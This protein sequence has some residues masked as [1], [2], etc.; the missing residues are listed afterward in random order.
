M[1]GKINN[2]FSLAGKRKLPLQKKARWTSPIK[3]TPGQVRTAS[4]VVETRLPAETKVILVSPQNTS[5]S[6]SASLNLYSWNRLI[7]DYFDEISNNNA[8]TCQDSNTDPNLD[9]SLTSG[10]KVTYPDAT[11]SSGPTD[12]DQ[13]DLLPG[14]STTRST[15]SEK[16]VGKLRF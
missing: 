12:A 11:Q 7:D 6:F 14:A 3:T 4:T 15:A 2:L 16:H 9:L 8:P 10:E 13:V 1:C 5:G